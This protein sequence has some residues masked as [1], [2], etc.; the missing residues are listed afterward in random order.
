MPIYRG[1][2]TDTTKL[3]SGVQV[4]AYNASNKNKVDTVISDQFGFYQFNDIPVGH[5]ELR[6]FGGGYGKQDWLTISVAAN[7]SN[8][9]YFIKPENGP[10]IKNRADTVELQLMQVVQGKLAKTTSGS[11]QLY[12]QDQDTFYPLKEQLGLNL[13]QYLNKVTI[14]SED[15]RGLLSEAEVEMTFSK[16]IY[17]SSFISTVKAGFVEDGAILQITTPHYVLG[18]SV[19]GELFSFIPGNFEDSEVN[20]E[21]FAI[22]N[23]GAPLPYYEG[24]MNLE[25]SENIESFYFEMSAE[26]ILGDNGDNL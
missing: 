6:F 11:V 15:L 25:A 23:P 26:R 18:E 24:S 10:F 5:Y 13:D 17:E 2:L 8:V 14:A 9:E 12:V 3:L 7:D 4:V 16:G 1:K 21:Q 19:D 22:D 20:L